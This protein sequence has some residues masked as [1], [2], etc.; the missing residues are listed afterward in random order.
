MN[1]ELSMDKNRRRSTIYL[2]LF[3]SLL[4]DFFQKYND[5]KHLA[6]G[7]DIGGTHALCCL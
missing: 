6:I 3:I 7:V 5:M 2:K 4:I 1:F